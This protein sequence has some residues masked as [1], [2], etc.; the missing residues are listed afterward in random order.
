MFKSIDAR[1][2]IVGLVPVLLLSIVGIL[3]G[4]SLSGYL[5]LHL[6]T[7][8]S[9]EILGVSVILFISYLTYYELSEVHMDN[10]TANEFVGE[11]VKEVLHATKWI[12]PLLTSSAYLCAVIFASIPVLHIASILGIIASFCLY[13]LVTLKIFDNINFVDS[14]GNIDISSLE[15]DMDKREAYVIADYVSRVHSWWDTINMPTFV[16]YTALYMVVIFFYHTP[17]LSQPGLHVQVE[18]FASGAASFHLILSGIHFYT[19]N[20]N[21]SLVKE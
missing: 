15:K 18:A 21:Y 13:D 3:I 5:T 4:K 17:I 11:N 14:S 20:N 9:V 7:F 1:I 16:G 6:N 8:T 10:I 2:I 19:Y 12:C